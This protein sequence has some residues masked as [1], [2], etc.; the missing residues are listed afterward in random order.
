MTSVKHDFPEE[1]VHL[2]LLVGLLFQRMHDAL[3]D[4]DWQGL[5]QSHFR[6][7]QGVPAEGISVTDLAERIGMTKQG[8]GQFVAALVETGHLAVDADPTDARVRLV[9]RTQHGQEALASFRGRILAFE[10]DLATEIGWKRYGSFRRSL[11]EL[12]LE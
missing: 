3:E 7:M 2:H 4:F 11:E 8:C 9:R 5:R 12:V 10:D 6:V 1:E